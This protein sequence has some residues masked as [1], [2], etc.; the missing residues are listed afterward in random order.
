M[1][2]IGPIRASTNTRADWRTPLTVFRKLDE[3]FWFALDAAAD[4]DNKLCEAYLSGPCTGEVECE[5]G[6]CQSWVSKVASVPQRSMGAWLNPPYGQ[7]EEVCAG[8]CKKKSCIKRGEHCAVRV[9]GLNDWVEKCI[10]SSLDGLTVVA[11]LPDSLDTSWFRSVFKT[12]WEIRIVEG[13]IQF[14]LPESE[15][16]C[17]VPVSHSKECATQIPRSDANTGGSIIVVWRPGVR[18]YGGP[19][20]SL[21]SQS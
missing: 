7:G 17:T 3:E 16:D 20:F 18:P 12:A 13:R 15:C 21:W 10:I 19:V 11:L 8:S 5:C 1:S 9:P 6:I 14:E 2:A 4:A